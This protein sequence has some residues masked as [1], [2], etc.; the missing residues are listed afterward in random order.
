MSGVIVAF[1]LFECRVLARFHRVAGVLPGG[2]SAEQGVR[3]RDLFLIHLE[4][5][6]GTRV[7]GPSG[8]IDDYLLP[9]WYCRKLRF[10]RSQWNIQCA[11]NVF[12]LIGGL[13]AAVDYYRR[14]FVIFLF[15]ILERN[16]R[17][18][19]IGIIFDKRR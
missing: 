15:C 10:G 17:N 9:L 18:F 13:A 4:C 5:Q 16:A 8:T 11:F 3:C 6:T 14:S 1:V 12:L 7:F 2:G 19:S